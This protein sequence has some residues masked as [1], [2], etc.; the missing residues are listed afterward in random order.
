M[1]QWLKIV[2]KHAKLNP[3]KSLKEYL[4]DAQVE[5]KKLKQS[6]KVV[7]KMVTGKK[8]A[9]VKTK[10]K[11]RKGKR[12]TKKHRGGGKDSD[13]ADAD[14]DADAM[15]NDVQDTEE[16]DYSTD[17]NDNVE[18]EEEEES[19]SMMGGKKGGFYQA[20]ILMR[21]RT[22]AGGKKGGRRSRRG[23]SRKGGKKPTALDISTSQMLASAP[24]AVA[25][26]RGRAS[27][28]KK[29][30]RSRKTSKRTRNMHSDLININ[31]K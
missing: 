31:L 10:H 16:I 2:K 12:H 14:A 19:D 29:L 18:E 30:K 7:L 27:A 17:M 8:K 5:Y 25:M 9:H 21:G 26:S 13:D 1:S 28:G 6:G 22:R 15:D 11:K 20:P 23:G 3:G 24:L 4:P